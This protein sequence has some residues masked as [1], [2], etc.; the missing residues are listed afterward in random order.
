MNRIYQIYQVTKHSNYFNKRVANDVY[1]T[2][3][4]YFEN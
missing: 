2:E 1:S 3:L 4:L